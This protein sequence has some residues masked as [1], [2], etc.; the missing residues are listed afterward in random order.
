MAGQTYFVRLHSITINTSLTTEQYLLHVEI[1]IAPYPASRALYIHHNVL[2]N[3]WISPISLDS[4]HITFQHPCHGACSSPSSDI[5]TDNM[6]VM[7][8]VMVHV[9]HLV[10]Y[11][12]TAKC[13]Q[14]C[15][16]SPQFRE[17]QLDTGQYSVAKTKLNLGTHDFSIAKPRVWNELPHHFE[18]ISN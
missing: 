7:V 18:I 16:V 4:W 10:E 15:Q 2:M 8:H 9:I 17:V 6:H 12:L 1:L 14:W 11:R 5:W 3:L 13:C